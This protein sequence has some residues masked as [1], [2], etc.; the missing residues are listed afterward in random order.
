[1][2]AS[3]FNP[4]FFSCSDNCAI[5]MQILFNFGLN[6]EARI[7]TTRFFSF[8][9]AAAVTA[10]N[11]SLGSRRPISGRYFCDSQS[12]VSFRIISKCWFC[13]GSKRVKKVISSRKNKNN[14]LRSFTTTFWC[15]TW[16]ENVSER[17]N[18]IYPLRQWKSPGIAHEGTRA[19]ITC[20][21]RA[22]RGY[23]P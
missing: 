15:I 16:G 3:Y 14:F 17:I 2:R 8:A 19:F 10:V 4:I 1:M 13:E 11:F 18:T 6:Y 12:K 23:A 20:S 5:W 22:R 7:L 21:A 9:T